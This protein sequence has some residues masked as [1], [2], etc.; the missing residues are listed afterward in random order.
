MCNRLKVR[1]ESARCSLRN[2]REVR[3]KHDRQQAEFG[4]PTNGNCI[5]PI[6]GI[7]SKLF[8]PLYDLA[9]GSFQFSPIRNFDLRIIQRDPKMLKCN[10]N[11]EDKSA[12]IRINKLGLMCSCEWELYYK[13]NLEKVKRNTGNWQGFGGILLVWL[14]LSLIF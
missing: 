12:N 8:V 13:I 6:S 1:W 4:V 2:N 7:P 10:I 11:G 9:T 14:A 5:C 3:W